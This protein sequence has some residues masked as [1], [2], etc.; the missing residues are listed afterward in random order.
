MILIIDYGLGNSK[1]ISNMLF[2][3]GIENRISSDIELIERADKYILPGVGSYDKAMSIIKSSKW[4]KNL[5]NNV[6]KLK[7]PLLGICLG[8][9]ILGSSSQEG[10]RKG[11]SWIDAEFIEFDN[12][13]LKP[14]MGWNEV[15][16]KNNDLFKNLSI[17]RFY[18]AH[19]FYLDKC[20]NFSIASSHYKDIFSCAINYKNIFGVQFH[21]EKSHKFGLQLLKNF[22]EL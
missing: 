7:K 4:I 3:L 22:F 12:D 14:H 10:K 21:P 1:S 9:Q 18:F 16:S 13:I 19:S 2:K 6:L 8:M 15:Q 11:L 5:E 20:N 17:S